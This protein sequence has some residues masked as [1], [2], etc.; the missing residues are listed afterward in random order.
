M[1]LSLAK[2]HLL[3]SADLLWVL[4]MLPKG[5]KTQTS[6]TG[7]NEVRPLTVAVIALGRTPFAR[8]LMGKFIQKR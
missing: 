7:Q 3:H 2:K 1:I 5:A 6:F 8:H 4:S